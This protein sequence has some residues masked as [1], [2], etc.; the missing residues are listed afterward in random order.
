[1]DEPGDGEQGDPTN[2]QLPPLYKTDTTNSSE[3]STISATEVEVQPGVP[4]FPPSP[5]PRKSSAREFPDQ[6]PAVPLEPALLSKL[7]FYIS[8]ILKNQIIIRWT[9]Q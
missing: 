3:I 7:F 8:L 2:D 1:M 4:P 6:D 5:K 9:P